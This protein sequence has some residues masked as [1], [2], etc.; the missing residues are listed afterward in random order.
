[1]QAELHLGVRVHDAPLAF[2]SEDLALEPL[3]TALQLAHLRAQLRVVGDQGVGL[4]GR[5]GDRGGR[6]W[7]KRIIP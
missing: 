6:E 7:H 3:D 5:Q 4:I 1:L 2:L